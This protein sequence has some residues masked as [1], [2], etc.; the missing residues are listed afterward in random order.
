MVACLI[1]Y[2]FEM[3][4]YDKITGIVY[5]KL[6]ITNRQFLIGNSK[7]QIITKKVSV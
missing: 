1:N 5:M 4:V 7:L 3:K 6:L 2:S